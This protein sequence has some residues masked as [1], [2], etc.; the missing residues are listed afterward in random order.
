MKRRRM[1]QS[2]GAAVLG[3]PLAARCGW[4]E[5]K[6]PRKILFFSRSALFEHPVIRREGG[7]LSFAEKALVEMA[8]QIDC[9]VDCTKDGRVFERDLDAYAAVV[10]YTCG[11]PEH[12]LK[13]IKADGHD[14][15][16]PLSESGWNNLD[17]AVR[18]GKPFVAVHP[19]LWLLPEAAGA[20]C[21]GHGSQ[22]VAR[23]NVVSPQFPGAEQLGESFSMLEEW[24][25][26]MRFAE[27]L[28]V[29]LVQDCAGM[30]KKAAVDRRC[31]DRSP[32]PCTWARMHGKGRVFYTSLG[33]RE[34]VWSSKIFEQ[35][36]LGGMSWALDRMEADVT[37]NLD[38][39]APQA[40]EFMKQ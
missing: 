39:V 17:A 40:N 28:H 15:N 10:S 26:L 8:R 19:G 33:H 6:S 21:L 37:P 11:R 30:D 31:Y 22:Q 23:I 34:D 29:V 5:Q 32:F 24:F 3:W 38:Q 20:D 1:L 18:E 36:L 13:P 35:I 14:G 2:L 16:Q 7:Q 25:F 4:A 12:L 9:T 27:D